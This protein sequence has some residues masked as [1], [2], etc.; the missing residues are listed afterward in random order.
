[1]NPEVQQI[2][3][4]AGFWI[5]CSPMVL[6]VLVQ[7]ILFM[8][9]AWKTG[10]AIGMS[11]KTLRRGVLT[12]TN[13]AIAPV[14]SVMIALV[15][16]ISMVGPALAW[17]RLSV[18]GAI[19]F[20]G[21]AVSTVLDTV[22]QTVAN[23]DLN[24][25]TVIVWVMAI[26][27][28]GWLLVSGLLTHK[29][30]TIRNKMVGKRTYLLPVISVCAGIGCYSYQVAKQVVTWSRH[31]I[32]ALSAIV[33]MIVVTFIANK[34]NSRFLKDWSLGIAMIGGMLCAIIGMQM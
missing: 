29:M 22:G 20:E 32:S 19:M 26:G 8:R 24:T 9:K 1:M 34:L 7:A 16:L 11:P 23:Y 12:A 27:S 2:T 15:G 4:S 33:I 30:D 5:A 21:L 17:L 28:S 31:S 10:L 18:I 14:F 25:F 13:T 3:S 6:I